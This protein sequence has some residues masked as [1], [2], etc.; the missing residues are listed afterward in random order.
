[1]EGVYATIQNGVRRNLS[2]HLLVPYVNS[3]KGAWFA[4]FN[5]FTRVQLTIFTLFKDFVK[6]WL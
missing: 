1:M 2:H 3:P 5:R 6:D 4:P